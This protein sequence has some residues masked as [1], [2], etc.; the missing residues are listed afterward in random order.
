V[1]PQH[2]RSSRGPPQCHCRAGPG[3][4][5]RCEVGPSSR[6][7][8][9]A[10]PDGELGGEGVAYAEAVPHSNSVPSAQMACIMT[11]SLRA[12]AT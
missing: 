4:D 8:K 5:D 6:P 1:P 11:A 12:T 7:G 9:D 2:E 10:S 3:R